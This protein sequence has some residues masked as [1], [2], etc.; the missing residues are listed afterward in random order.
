MQSIH[1]SA[2]IAGILLASLLTTACLANNNY[3]LPGDVFFATELTLAD[4]EGLIAAKP[5]KR[6]IEYVALDRQGGS[7]CGYA[8]YANAII[9]TVDDAFARNLRKV[10]DEIRD[11]DCLHVRRIPH[12]RNEFREKKVMRVLFYPEG[13][14]FRVLHLG[15]RY[16]E[17]WV[18]EVI[19]FGHPRERI[20][21][22]SM[23]DSSEA[24]AISWR[25]AT[26]VHGLSATIPEVALKPVPRTE[27]PMVI[28]EKVWAIVLGNGTL[29][30]FFV[31]DSSSTWHL[32]LVGSDGYER[33][34]LHEWT[35]TRK[36]ENIYFL[37]DESDDSGGDEDGSP[38]DRR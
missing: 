35:W 8:G 37:K 25:D 23:V 32:Y 18:E 22:Q 9:P 29:N 30:N 24:V 1:S 3:F 2:R 13:Y 27:E 33:W 16:N 11:E 7:L 6:R 28:T 19:K 5:D 36:G 20:Q 15:L 12:G 31:Q 38:P 17:S 34:E 21:Y 26:L 4:I 10:Y 14:D